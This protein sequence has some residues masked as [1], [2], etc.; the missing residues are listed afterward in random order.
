MTQVVRGDEMMYE[1]WLAETLVE[2]YQTRN[3]YELLECIGA[4]VRYFY[5]DNSSS[6]KGFS[7][8]QNRVM[9]AAIN[10]HL[11]EHEKLIVVGHEAGHLIRHRD[12]ILLS[13]FQALRD[14]NLYDNSGRL[15]YQANSFLA[16]FLVSDKD[17]LELM[18]ND[19]IDYFTLASELYIPPPLLA[20]KL[21]SMMLRDYKVSSPEGLH[22]KFLSR[23][24]D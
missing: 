1:Y 16:D 9:F 2:K 21:H 6:L 15:E 13:P 8:I 20:F 4:K 22:S 19:D 14:F 18:S 3:P 24:N 23:A 17:V 11:N 7:T 12:E 5:D 10:G